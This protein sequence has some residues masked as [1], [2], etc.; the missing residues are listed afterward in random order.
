[1]TELFISRDAA[2]TFLKAIKAGYIRLSDESMYSE[3]AEDENVIE[4]ISLRNSIP[5]WILR[6][7]HE[8]RH[9][10]YSIQKCAAIAESLLE[11][12]PVTLRVNEAAI[13]RNYAIESLSKS[14]INCK[15]GRLS[16]VSL[17]LNKRMQ[18]NTNEL[19]KR[20]LIEVQD[21]SSQLAAFALA[22]KEGER[23]LDA[24]AGAGGKTLHLA[25]ICRD[26]CRIISSDTEILRLKEIRKRASRFGFKSI[27]TLLLKNGA[28]PKELSVG[29][30]A[31]LV[32]AP[33]SGTGVLRRQP[34]QKWKISP[35]SIRKQS[36]KQ[37]EILEFYSK[38][39]KKGGRLVYSTCSLLPEE[40]DEVVENFLKRNPEFHPSPFYHIFASKEINIPTMNE[41][42]Y[43]LSITPDMFGSDGFFISKF[44]RE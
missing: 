35:E 11:P 28:S 37:L 3:T 9:T 32:D 15:M 42:T 21:E 14:E 4:K 6:D 8:N 30:N 13:D 36:A 34:M 27:T 10:S 2:S 17:I 16:P 44:I 39:V 1:L 38:T 19:F 24:C 41:D 7:L 18:L 12:P 31:V 23:I 33:C 29:F 20:G 25:S 43:K 40:N 26:K 22:P 5:D